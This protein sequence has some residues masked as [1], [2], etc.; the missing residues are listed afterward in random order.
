M[1]INTTSCRDMSSRSSR[2][3]S[4]TDDAKQLHHFPLEQLHMCPT[5]FS[6]GSFPLTPFRTSGNAAS[7]SHRLS[8]PQYYP[9]PDAWLCFS[10]SC[11]HLSCTAT[12]SA[13]SPV[14]LLFYHERCLLHSRKMSA[15]RSLVHTF[16]LVGVL[17]P[18]AI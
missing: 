11:E 1:S 12:K 14:A 10:A 9:F 2:K 17:T 18:R 16:E 6:S 7:L 3:I 15:A 8:L 5:N 13:E 4:F